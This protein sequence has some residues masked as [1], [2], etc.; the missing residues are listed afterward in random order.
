MTGFGRYTSTFNNKTFSIDI[1]SLNSKQTDISVRIPSFYR[2][3][4]MEIRNMAQEKLIRGKIDIN[5]FIEHS[6]SN[7]VALLNKEVIANYYKQLKEISNELGI[8]THESLLSNILRMPEVMTSANEKL[9]DKEWDFVKS[10]INSA[11]DACIK[12]RISEGE[13]LEKDIIDSNQNIID[14]LKRIAPYETERLQT[15][16]ERIRQNII[17]HLNDD[18]K[19]DNGRLEQEM[20]FYIERMD[21]NEEKVRLQKHCEY[22]LETINC[23]SHSGKKL[24]FITQEIGREINTLGSK[25][26]HAEMQK[27]VVQMKDEL[28]KIKEQILNIL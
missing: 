23:S 13:I 8:N 28:E 14:L 18:S 25:S 6:G 11:I 22:L 9:D 12:H 27:I 4:E 10:G 7:N 26:Y 3:K 5:I 1:K 21:I 24:G 19:L 20:I 16:K 17:E 2:E 15:V